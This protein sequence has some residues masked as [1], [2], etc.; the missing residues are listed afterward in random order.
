MQANYSFRDLNWFR[1]RLISWFGEFG[2]TY[3]WRETKDPYYILVSEVMLRRTWASQVEPV[4]LE[5][6][7]LYPDISALANAEHERVKRL[8]LSLGLPKRADDICAIGRELL[9]DFRGQVPQT[10]DEL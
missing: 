3:P 4:Y 1:R 7:R 10:R 8:M 5:F 6:I 9:N 2:R